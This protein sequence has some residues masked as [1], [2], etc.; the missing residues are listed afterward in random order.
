MSSNVCEFD[1]Y[2]LITEFGDDYCE[3]ILDLASEKSSYNPD[4]PQAQRKERWSKER[5]LGRGG[6]GTVWLE[7][8]ERGALRAVKQM[9]KTETCNKEELLALTRLKTHPQHFVELFGWF[10]NEENIY[11]AMEYMK[12]GDLNS[13]ILKDYLTEIHAKTITIQVLEGLKI[14]HENGF[15]HRDLK[16]QNILVVSL[17]PM[18]VKI[19]DFGV[20]KQVNGTDLRT[21]VGTPNYT[22]PEVLGYISSETSSYTNAV[23]IW[24][25]GCLI[26]AIITK[27]T[28][29]T[30][31]RQLLNYV[32]GQAPFPEMR[33]LDNGTSSTAIKL[34]ASLMAVQP[35]KRLTA[36]Q[37]LGHP[38]LSFDMEVEEADTLWTNL[39]DDPFMLTAGIGLGIMM[40]DDHEDQPLHSC[41]TPY[42]AIKHG[43]AIALRIHLQEYSA[44][45][46]AKQR[47]DTT[48]LHMIAESGDEDMMR[49]FLEYGVNTNTRDGDG[50]TALDLSIK[51][52]NKEIVRLLLK[53]GASAA[54]KDCFGKSALHHV[55]DHAHWNGQW[56]SEEVVKL[57]LE[58]G[59]DAK[60]KDAQGNTALHKAAEEGYETIVQL[61]FT[62]GASITKNNSGCTALHMAAS[63]GHTNIVRILLEKGADIMDKNNSGCTA[64]HQATNSDFAHKDTVEFLL[65][66][67]VAIMAKN[68]LHMTALDNAVQKGDQ[69]IVELLLD[70]GAEIVTTE[71]AGFNALHAAAQMQHEGIA[72][73]LVANGPKAY[74][75]MKNEKGETALDVAAQLGCESVV[76]IL[77]ESVPEIITKTTTTSRATAL[78]LAVSNGHEQIVR[79]LLDSGANIMAKDGNGSTALHLAVANGDKPIVE[80]LIQNGANT[81][82]KNSMGKEPLKMAIENGYT[83]IQ[84]VLGKESGVS[85]VHALILLLFGVGLFFGDTHG[86]QLAGGVFGSILAISMF[87][88]FFSES[89]FW[90]LGVLGLG[91]FFGGAHGSDMAVG[92]VVVMLYGSWVVRSLLFELVKE[93]ELSIIGSG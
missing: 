77:L 32:G 14:M 8:N 9:A 30:D 25:L 6:F 18:T 19:G 28:P 89:L 45:V 11:L 24:S 78:H 79:L 52:G 44:D 43:N 27:E 55:L 60:A 64:L 31:T 4:T 20:S 53:G 87:R 51:K 58:Y 90:I 15:C 42:C 76:K 84:V 26:H 70:N 29:F 41:P 16:P 2:R 62:F 23:D 63:S 59:A 17:S 56:Y 10:E 81:K 40:P 33:M 12:H 1:Q 75:M 85:N 65:G 74:P 57:L 46:N 3:H 66:R 35:E 5:I 92:L 48:L 21:M 61:L 7:K 72:K 38:W 39:S 54:E 37:A 83:D 34:I 22:A 71:G 13:L 82:V 80:L 47:G 67:G 36:E 49:L 69:D 86:A 73:L 93:Q 91:L 68:D 50:R 88:Y